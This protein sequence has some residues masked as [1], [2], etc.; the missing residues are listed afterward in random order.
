M[1]LT[2]VRTSNLGN[3]DT[4]PIGTTMV[5]YIATDNQG[6]EATCSFTV[7]ITEAPDMIAPVLTNCPTDIVVSNETGVCEAV[8]NW[9]APSATDNSANVD[10]STDFDPGSAFPVGTTTV[11][12]TA[13]DSAGNQATCS[14][15]VTVED[16]EVPTISCPADIIVSI[17]PG[18]T[19]ATITFANPMFS[20]NCSTPVLTQINGLTSDSNFPLGTTINSFVVTDEAG[21][22][23]TCSFNVIVVEQGVLQLTGLTD[24]TQA[25]DTDSC[26]A[27]IMIPEPTVING[28]GNI[29][30]T[31][32]LGD[33][34][35]TG[36]FFLQGA[37]EVIYQAVDDSTGQM[38]SDTII[39]T[40]N[41]NQAPAVSCSGDISVDVSASD[42]STVVNYLPPVG[43]DNCSMVSIELIEGL[44]SGSQFPLGTTTNTFQFTDTSGN[45][46]TC[47]FDVIVT[48]PSAIEITGLANITQGNDSGVCGA[49]VTLP[50]PGINGVIGDVYILTS[51]GD[52]GA[53]VFFSLGD[54]EVVYTVSTTSG[55]I[56]RD[57]IS[58]TVNDTEAPI[59]D[60]P[61]DTI[62]SI[63][64][65]QSS[66]LFDYTPPIGSDL[67]SGFSIEQIG[68]LAPGASFP[69]GTTTNE[70]SNY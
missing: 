9:T 58:V 36:Y 62:I 60:C 57:T 43:V 65:G 29:T 67:C 10:L 26:G 12:Y 6:N 5:T 52:P 68:G 27:T 44:A 48:A 16:N 28:V 64:P 1:N 13:Q 22:A 23:D 49:M 54:T 19:S 7:T 8:V 53:N 18:D 47:S 66:I 70:F 39:I 59:I 21:N 42:T 2:P 31:T 38:T 24:I 15:T 41:D 35:S 30:I 33:D 25:N 4:F 34:P 3:G 32:S 69:V 50:T 11:T 63:T 40:V 20:D 17:P 14:F 61:S 45:V 56:A 51:S 37:T 55:Q 46:A